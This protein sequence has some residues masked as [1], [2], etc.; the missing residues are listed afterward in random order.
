LQKWGS[1]P[2]HGLSPKVYTFGVA[3]RFH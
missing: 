2:P 3:Y 1:F